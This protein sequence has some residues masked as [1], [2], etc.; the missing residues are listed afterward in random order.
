MSTFQQLIQL[1]AALRHPKKGCPWDI[2]QTNQSISAYTLEETYE[3]LHAIESKDINNLKEELGDLLFHIVFH[4]RIAEEQGHF[5]I[6][7]VINAIIEKMTQRH[8]HVFEQDRDNRLSDEDLQQQWEEHKQRDKNHNN[9]VLDEIG[10]KLPAL[11]RAQ[12]LQEAAAGYHF[13][14]PDALPV[15]DKIEEEIEEIRAAIKT[16]EAD[17][18]KSEIGDLLFACINL[19]RHFELDAESALRQTN[20]KFIRRFDFV[21]AQMHAA[22]IEFGPE[23]LEQMEKFWQQSKKVTG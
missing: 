3:L 7:D 16:N 10:H 12:I 6:Q 21:Y 9:R 20:E 14:W 23:R 2:K 11:M 22:G 5:N 13:D 15:L 19:A 1:M 8:P 17:H 4:A 18:I